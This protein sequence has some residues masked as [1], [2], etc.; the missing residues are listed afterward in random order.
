MHYMI[1]N[2]LLHNTLLNRIIIFRI[3]Q[4]FTI[5]INQNS[6]NVYF[7]TYYERPII[8]LIYFFNITFK[9][10]FFLKHQN[11]IN[12]QPELLTSNSSDCTIDQLP[13]MTMQQRTGLLLFQTLALPLLYTVLL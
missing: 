9:N 2:H 12:H 3:Y 13:P 4:F 1:L 5:F 8:N 7:S 11:P 10:F 6:Y